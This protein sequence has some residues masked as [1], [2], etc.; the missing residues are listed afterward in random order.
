MTV[1]ALRHEAAAAAQDGDDQAAL[2]H[3]RDRCTALAG[4]G[5]A[6]GDLHLDDLELLA[7]QVE[8]VDEA[9]VRHLVLDQAQDQVGRRDGRLDAEQLEVLA[10][11]RVVDARDDALDEVLLPRDLAD[12]HVVLVVAGDR[13]D[14]VGALD[15]GAL[16]HPQ[17]GAV[18]V[19]GGV[20]ELVLDRQVAI[21]ALLDQRDLVALVEQLAREV[22]PDLAASDDDRVHQLALARPASACSNI[23]IA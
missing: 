2:G 16:E 10:V 12:E 13:D 14:E 8:Q 19:L 21:A 22:Q 15:A 23:S 11:T 7:G 4:R 6:L 20:L 9:V 17:L 18:A 3:R 1:S 5:R